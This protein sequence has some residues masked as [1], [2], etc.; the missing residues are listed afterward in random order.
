MA[1]AP[2]AV[3][4]ALGY[5]FRDPQ[6]LTRALTHRSHAGTHNERLEFL[7]DAV[8]NLA[9]LEEKSHEEIARELGIGKAPTQPD[10]MSELEFRRPAPF[11]RK[12]GKMP[13][14]ASLALASSLIS[15]ATP[16][17]KSKRSGHI[18][19]RATARRSR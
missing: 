19:R 3:A 14:W 9:V 15:A 12:G 6:L 18:S 11:F 4:Q 13:E 16:A 1:S 5:R 2:E 8:L 10:A 17:G 7:G